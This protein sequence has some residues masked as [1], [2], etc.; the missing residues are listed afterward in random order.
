MNLQ[1]NVKANDGGGLQ[2]EDVEI[3][4]RCLDPNGVPYFNEE[5]FDVTELRGKIII[6]YTKLMLTLTLTFKFL[7]VLCIL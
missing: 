6:Y 2:S 1:L 7:Y 3:I 5:T 4:L